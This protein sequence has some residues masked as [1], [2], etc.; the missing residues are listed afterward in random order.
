MKYVLAAAAAILV[1]A[2]CGSDGGEDTGT[3]SSPTPGTDAGN[4][5]GETTVSSSGDLIAQAN[6]VCVASKRK[7]D[8]KLI[9][10]LRANASGNWETAELEKLVN[11]IVAPGFEQ[12]AREL[13]ALAGEPGDG[14]E[15]VLVTAAIEDSVD[16]ARQD[17]A[18]F[19]VGQKRPFAQSEA[20]AR[21][22]GLAACGHP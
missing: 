22:A 7:I 4:G 20:V 6:A 12:Q 5:G 1:L 21:R 19:A 9:P 8:A 16:R 15:L 13:R 3:A 14:G 18:G 17:P 2:G 10:L 11:D